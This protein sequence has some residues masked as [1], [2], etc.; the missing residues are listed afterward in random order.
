MIIEPLL[1]FYYVTQIAAYQTAISRPIGD[2]TALDK[3]DFKQVGLLYACLRATK[4]AFDLL[5]LI[6]RKSYFHFSVLTWTQTRLALIALQRLSIYDDPDWDLGYVHGT[7]DFLWVMEELYV[8]VEKAAVELGFDDD[9]VF[10][11]TATK[12]KIARGYCQERMAAHSAQPQQGVS[13]HIDLSLLDDMW[14]Q[15]AYGM[16][17]VQPNPTGIPD[18]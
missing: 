3:Q 4:S 17:D 14:F 16:F 15:N 10:P 7:L 13:D 9:H 18:M 6:D 11:R 8:R 2:N 5:F 12:M 1:V